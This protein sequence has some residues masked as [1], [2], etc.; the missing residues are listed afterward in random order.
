MFMRALFF[1]TRVFPLT[2]DRICA[3]AKCD[4]I[5]VPRIVICRI[6]SVQCPRDTNPKK[7]DFLI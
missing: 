5:F 7:R 4:T 1:F 3:H 2:F 6:C